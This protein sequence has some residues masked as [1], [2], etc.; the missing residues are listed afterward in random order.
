V[1][2]ARIYEGNLFPINNRITWGF[3]LA[4]TDDEY[5]KV[6]P[7]VSYRLVPKTENPEYRWVMSQ[8]ITLVQAE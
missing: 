7:G 8:D 1:V 2:E 3:W 4:L 5:K 6:V